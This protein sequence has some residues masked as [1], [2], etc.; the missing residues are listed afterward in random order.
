VINIFNHSLEVTLKTATYSCPCENTGVYGYFVK[1]RNAKRTLEYAEDVIMIL[2]ETKG[3]IYGINTLEVM[4]ISNSNNIEYIHLD[5]C[6][7]SVHLFLSV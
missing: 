1:H 7:Q 6:S 4:P 3:L 2:E 5:T